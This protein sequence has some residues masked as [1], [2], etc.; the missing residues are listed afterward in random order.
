VRAV[1]DEAPDTVTLRLRLGDATG[2]LP[3]QHSID[4]TDADAQ[5]ISAL[6]CTLLSDNDDDDVIEGTVLFDP[7]IGPF[8]PDSQMTLSEAVQ[9]MASPLAG[10]GDGNN[11]A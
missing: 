2:L 6:L 9:S 4:G 1:I 5:S 11:D 3:G 7:G 10:A 8:R